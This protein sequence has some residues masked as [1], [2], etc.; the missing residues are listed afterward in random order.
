MSAPYIGKR[1][2][3]CETSRAELNGQTATAVQFDREAGRYKVQLDSDRS[4]VMALKPNN[5]EPLPESEQDQGGGGGFPGG[6]GG[7]PGLPP[8]IAQYLNNPRFAQAAQTARQFAAQAQ[9]LLPP[10][11]DPKHALYAGGGV[12]AL[13]AF[14]VGMLRAAVLLGALM[15]A[16]M[17]A[18]PDYQANQG[19]GKIR[20]VLAGIKGSVAGMAD[21]LVNRINTT[22]GNKVTVPRMA[23]VPLVGILAAVLVWFAVVSPLRAGRAA[24]FMGSG[25]QSAVQSA[26]DQAYFLGYQDGS[27]GK[28]MGESKPENVQVPPSAPLSASGSRFGWSQM[29]S[30]GILGKMVFDLG[31][32]G[33]G[34]DPRFAMQSA[35]NLPTQQMMIA[36]F[37]VARLLGISPI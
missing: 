25:Q 35:R 29:I 21:D 26:V 30:V 16:V 8:F 19:S 3:I 20:A 9:R 36:G 6:T 12:F 31:K 23:G 32:T 18:M 34:W 22:L 27:Q 5:L 10:G 7:I 24:G 17:K 2:R 15:V 13:L 1:V 28:E 11:L 14:L 37:M 4:K 33:S